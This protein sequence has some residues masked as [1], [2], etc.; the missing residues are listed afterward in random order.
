MP[1][2]RAPVSPSDAALGRRGGGICHHF[3]AVSAGRL[4]WDLPPGVLESDNRFACYSFKKQ[5]FRCFHP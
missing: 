4:R 1:Q 3:L 2:R 5:S